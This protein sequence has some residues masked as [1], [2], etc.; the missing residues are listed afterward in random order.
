MISLWLCG[1]GVRERDVL[2]SVNGGPG[3]PAIYEYDIHAGVTYDAAPFSLA[4]GYPSTLVETSVPATWEAV[5]RAAGE[6]YT[7]T[8]LCLHVKDGVTD[9]TLQCQG[10]SCVGND[11]FRI[12]VAF[13]YTIGVRS[14]LRVCE[15]SVGTL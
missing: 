9:V 15:S 7:H 12:S 11:P 4:T 8:Q 2:V 14:C 6:M 10:A 1:S 5:V 13:D 3:Y